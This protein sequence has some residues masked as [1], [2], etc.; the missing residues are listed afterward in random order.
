MPRKLRIFYG[1]FIF[2]VF[3]FFKLLKLYYE[4]IVNKFV[5]QQKVIVKS[6]ENEQKKAR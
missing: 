2:K 3:N 1:G 6:L 5:K 4:F